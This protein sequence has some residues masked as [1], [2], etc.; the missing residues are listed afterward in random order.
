MRP[1]LHAAGLG[2]GHIPSFPL[3]P[4]TSGWGRARP[5]VPVAGSGPGHAPSLHW[6]GLGQCHNHPRP[7]QCHN[8]HPRGNV[9]TTPLGPAAPPLLATSSQMESHCDHPGHRTRTTIQIRLVDRQGTVHP[10]RWPKVEHRIHCCVA[11]QGCME[12]N[13]VA[14]KVDLV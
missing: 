11:T 12:T 6:A 3:S 9:I 1:S 8:H 13:E 7:G 14:W 2:L 5:S 4:N 10:A